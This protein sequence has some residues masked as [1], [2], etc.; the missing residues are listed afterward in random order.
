MN[1]FGAGKNLVHS[2]ALNLTVSGLL[3]ETMTHFGFSLIVIAAIGG[4]YLIVTGHYWW[5]WVPFLMA[6]SKFEY[7]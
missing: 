7:K 4:I 2:V 1:V 6:C 3:E 5:A